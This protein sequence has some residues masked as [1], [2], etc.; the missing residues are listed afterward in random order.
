[1]RIASLGAEAALASLNSAAA[2]LD[3]AE[4]ARRL[5]EFGPNRIEE[6]GRESLLLAFAREFTHFFAIVLWVGA[7]LAF[8]AEHY[9]PGQGMARLGIAIVGV[10]L[11]MGGLTFFPALT[12]GPIAEQFA[13]LHGDLF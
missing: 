1:M 6:V 13:M 10:I 2:G 9:D 12:L 8:L 7:G 11:I 3:A 4:A 5:A